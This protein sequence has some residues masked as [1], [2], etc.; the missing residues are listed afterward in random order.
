MTIHAEH[1]PRV[2][3]E[4]ADWESR[5]RMA[6]SN[7]KLN[8]GTFL[9][10]EDRL[11]PFSIN[12]FVSRINIQLPLYCSWRLDPTPSSLV[13]A[14]SISWKDHY[15]YMFPPTALIPHC[16]DKPREEKVTATLIAPVWPNQIGFPQLLKSLTDLP[17]LL[18]PTQDIVTNPDSLNHPMK[19]HLPPLVTWPLSRDP[20]MQ[21]DF[22]TE[23]SA[24]SGSHGKCQQSLVPGDSG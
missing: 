16:L 9:Q 11:G 24:S 2:E 17:T 12:I 5:H 10:L 6:S 14:L 7:W 8:W 3:N 1:L 19:D 4:Q 22:Q 20:T 13:D 23:L 18:L 21:K 15:P